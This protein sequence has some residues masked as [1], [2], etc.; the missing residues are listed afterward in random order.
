MAY[1][2]S[3]SP[4]AGKFI[5]TRTTAL[6]SRSEC[7]VPQ[8]RHRR[9]PPSVPVLYCFRMILRIETTVFERL[10]L[11]ALPP[12]R[13]QDGTS[14]MAWAEMKKTIYSLAPLRKLLLIA[15]RRD[16]A[17]ISAIQD[18]KA[19]KLNRISQPVRENDRTYRGLNFFD[20]DDEQLF[21]SLAS[22]EFSG[23]QNKDLRR[24]TNG[25]NSGQISRTM[26]RLRVPSAQNQ[27]AETPAKFGQNL[28]V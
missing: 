24:C 19:G 13:I 5:F 16:L 1:G 17:F 10:L 20:A 22:R 8:L 3:T 27:T 28:L 7:R 25:K 18:D 15:N 6:G 21:R 11:Q 26:K 23:F 12:G 9:R 2:A 14:K 4:V